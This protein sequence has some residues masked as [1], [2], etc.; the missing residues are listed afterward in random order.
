M[1]G[2][3]EEEAQTLGIEDCKVIDFLSFK[4]DEFA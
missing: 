3:L 1:A 2:V 4:E